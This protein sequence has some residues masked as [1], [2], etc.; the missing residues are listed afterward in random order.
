MD[1][2]LTQAVAD[3]EAGNFSRLE[4]LLLENKNLDH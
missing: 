4:T 2:L 1:E 3:L